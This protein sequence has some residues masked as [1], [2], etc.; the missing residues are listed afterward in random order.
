MYIMYV[1]VYIYIYIYVYVYIYIYMYVCVYIYIYISIYTYTH[2]HSSYYYYYYYLIFFTILIIYDGNSV[3][4]YL[5]VLQLNRSTSGCRHCCA[6]LL[7]RLSHR[8]CCL[9]L[10]VSGRPETATSFPPWQDPVLGLLCELQPVH[11][12]RGVLHRVPEGKLSQG[13]QVWVQGKT[14]C[15]C[16]ERRASVCPTF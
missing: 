5:W 11:L 6:L 14:P 13:I 3:R 9:L 15:R 1:C 10:L 2:I 8:Q 7:A 16:I 12:W 4:R